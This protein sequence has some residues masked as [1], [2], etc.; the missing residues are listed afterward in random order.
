MRD[1]FEFDGE[2]MKRGLGGGEAL[3]VE[4]RGRA[5]DGRGGREGKPLHVYLGR[6]LER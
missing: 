2:V 3:P 1:A 4:M 6:G 5:R